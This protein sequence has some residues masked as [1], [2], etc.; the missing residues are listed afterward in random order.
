MSRYKL[1]FAPGTF[2]KRTATRIP[3]WK[4]TV[5]G[6]GNHKRKTP[7]EKIIHW[8]GTPASLVV[9]SVFFL[10]MP[11]LAFFGVSKETVMLLLTT[12]VSLEAI[13]L[14]IFIQMGVNRQAEEQEETRSVISAGLHTLQ[15][16]IDEVQE[17]V[18]EEKQNK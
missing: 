6:K 9:H 14:S 1:V 11:C 13:Y 2:N 4:V 3:R 10:G 12:V 15:E 16:S 5:K 18:E 7:L 17:T 8:V